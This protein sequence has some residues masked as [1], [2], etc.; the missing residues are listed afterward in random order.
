MR[1]GSLIR[2]VICVET[3]GQRTDD[4]RRAQQL[5]LDDSDLETRW[6]EVGAGHR[7]QLLERG[8]GAPMVI[9]HG[10]GPGASFLRPLLDRLDGIR[11]IAPDRPGQGLSAPVDI[12]RREFRE[13]A[14]RW[15]GQFL[16]TLGLDR[17]A[18]AGHSMG[19]L[20][21]LWYAL[22]RSDR[23][24]RLV[25][26]APPQ[27]PGTR[28]PFPFRLM[29]TR[30]LFRLVQRVSP[31]SPHSSLQFAKLMGEGDT[32]VD[33]P[34][35]IDVMVAGGKD[36]VI[37]ATN[38]NEARAIVSP[39]AV[40]TP[41]G[42][43]RRIRVRPDELGRITAPTLL[44]WGD[45]E[46]LGSVEVAQHIARLIPNATLEVVPAGHAPWLGQP[47]LTAKLINEF[48]L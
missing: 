20:W 35:L 23:V 1:G 43:R 24:T 16:D 27:L 26:L 21:A 36:P 3:V 46:P 22:A 18:L 39:A 33:H 10:T 41:S 47:D 31:P 48:A 44:I 34:D 4:Y 12:T 38:L 40:I 11:V 5:V 30:G 37:V 29:G 9:L 13:R 2:T 32:L 28:C 8:H 19:G 15:V 7:V 6:I 14:V 42:F 17:V 45:R 25:L